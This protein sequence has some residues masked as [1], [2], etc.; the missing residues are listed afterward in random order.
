ML[1]TIHTQEFI[2]RIG[3]VADALAY[4]PSRSNHD[5]GACMDMRRPEKPEN[6]VQVPA[7]SLCH[8]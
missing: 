2:E 5:R 6:R 7:R 8:G 3:F 1:N 4:R